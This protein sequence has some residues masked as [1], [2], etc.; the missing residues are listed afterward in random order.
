MGCPFKARVSKLFETGAGFRFF[1]TSPGQND[2]KKSLCFES[3]SNSVIFLPKIVVIS[4]KKKALHFDS[5]SNFAV[6]LLKSWFAQ[7]ENLKLGCSRY[8]SIQNP[9]VT[10]SECM[11]FQKELRG[12]DEKP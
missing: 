4:K 6:F 3:I 9:T 7:G 1:W 5:S 12:P 11:R 2:R 10:Q 8:N